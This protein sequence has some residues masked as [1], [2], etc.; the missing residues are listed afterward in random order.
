MGYYDLDIPEEK[1]P[2]DY[3]YRERRAELL[4]LAIRAGHPD[5]ISPTKMAKRYDVVKSTISKD[6]D[7]I[8]EEIHDN[9]NDDAEMVTSVVYRK[10][11]REL[12]DRGDYLDAVEVL[13]SWNEWLFD[14]GEQQKTPEEIDVNANASEAYLEMLKETGA[15]D[16]EDLDDA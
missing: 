9:L 12:M 6:M 7:R 14:V 13:E 15:V 1:D 3:N 16:D 11:I 10:S 5:Q 8:A 2:A 4:K